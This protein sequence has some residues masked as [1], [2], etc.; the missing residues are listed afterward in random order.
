MKNGKK[1]LENSIINASSF[2]FRCIA[3]FF[4][5]LLKNLKDC[6]TEF[7]NGRGLEEV[8]EFVCSM[9]SKG[10]CRY[11]VADVLGCPG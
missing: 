11:G 2:S 7:I 10:G 9:D 4:F 8:Y 3:E 5:G 6:C 1:L